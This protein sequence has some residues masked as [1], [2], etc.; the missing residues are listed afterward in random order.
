MRYNSDIN[1]DAAPHD[2]LLG[3]TVDVISGVDDPRL[4]AG[5][6]KVLGFFLDKTEGKR[7]PIRKDFTPFDLRAYLPNIILVDL[8]YGDDGVPCDAIL[9][10]IG[11]ELEVIFGGRAGVNLIDHPSGVGIRP[12]RAAQVLIQE[13]TYMVGQAKETLPDKPFWT[14]TSVNIPLVDESGKITQM[15]FHLQVSSNIEP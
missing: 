10:V 1:S 8:V 2:G 14:T 5:G 9:R 15:L 7:L 12:I 13:R 6:K 4:T 3:Y 11:S